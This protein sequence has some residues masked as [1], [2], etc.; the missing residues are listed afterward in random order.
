MVYALPKK[1]SNNGIEDD[2]NMQHNAQVVRGEV[3]EQLTRT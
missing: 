3:G 1:I 2:V